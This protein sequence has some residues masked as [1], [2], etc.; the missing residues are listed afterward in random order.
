MTA[1]N[2]TNLYSA[3][4]WAI[5]DIV[6][7]RSYI[8]DTRDSTGTARRFVYNS[9]PQHKATDFGNFP[10]IICEDAMIDHSEHQRA[11][12]KSER[13]TW[14]T[15]ITVRTARDGAGNNRSDAGLNDMRTIV[16][17]ILQTFKSD[18]VKYILRK[19]NIWDLQ[20]AVTNVDSLVYNQKQVHE[21]EIEILFRTHITVSL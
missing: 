5:Y 16:N 4:S 8:T 19:Q 13:I 6:N 20:I 15:L 18:A 9:E 7:T 3:P 14:R 2:R 11:D 17:S 10:Y 21:T 12:H 1:I